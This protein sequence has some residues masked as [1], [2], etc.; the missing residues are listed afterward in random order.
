[1]AHYG[2]S[3]TNVSLLVRLR[4]D[5]NDHTAWG[6][7]VRQYGRRI[8]QWCERWHLQEADA[9]DVTQNV[10]IEVARQIRTFSYD[11]SRSFRG[12][13]KTLTH[14]AWCDW[15]E[16]QRRQASGSGD[17]EV[18][19]LLNSIQARDELIRTLEEQ[20]DTELLEEAMARVRLRVEPRSWEAFRLLG[21]ENESGAEAAAKLGMKIGAV[22]MAKSRVQKMIQTEIRRLEQ[23]DEEAQHERLPVR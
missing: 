1:M 9:R 19:D 16:K 22:F 11:P 20:Y 6:E 5:P 13:L 14:G 23:Q 21:V 4:Y 18:L 17:S 3:D 7:F 8:L 2:A 12:W 15:L 10:L